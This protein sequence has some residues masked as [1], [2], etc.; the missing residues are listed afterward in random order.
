MMNNLPKLSDVDP[1]LLTTFGASAMQGLR[2]AGWLERKVLPLD[3]PHPL[4]ERPRR[5]YQADYIGVSRRYGGFCGHWAPEPGKYVRGP[6][7][8]TQQE[9]AEDRARAL[10]LDYLE[11]RNGA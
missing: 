11:V 10:G 6:V 7:R 5:A 8:E 3:K 9:A 1:A 2:D 4:P